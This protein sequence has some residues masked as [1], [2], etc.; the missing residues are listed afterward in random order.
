[1]RKAFV[2][3]FK[4]LPKNNERNIPTIEVN[5][6]CFKPS[7]RVVILCFIISGDVSKYKSPYTIP[8]NVPKSP[9]VTNTFGI[10]S[11]K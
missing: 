2:L 1:M 5:I 7:K 4:I 8:V 3:I 11:I 9:R 6:A 10:E